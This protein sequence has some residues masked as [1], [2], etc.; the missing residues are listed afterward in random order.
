MQE[1]RL[2]RTGLV[3]AARQHGRRRGLHSFIGGK[4]HRLRLRVG[5]FGGLHIGGH[6]GQ[7]F[8]FNLRQGSK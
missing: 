8:G 3:F 4:Q 2:I 1:Q 7:Q 6:Y 5:A